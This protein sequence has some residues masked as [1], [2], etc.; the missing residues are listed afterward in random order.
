MSELSKF[1]IKA[2]AFCL[3][4]AGAA[5]ASIG[6][7]LIEYAQ[8]E[9]VLRYQVEEAIGVEPSTKSCAASTAKD[10]LAECKTALYMQAVIAGAKAQLSRWIEILTLLGIVMGVSGGAIFLRAALLER[11]EAQTS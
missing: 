1:L 4:G 10:W 2:A 7:P 6:V 8:Q 9:R 11:R 3:I 5:V